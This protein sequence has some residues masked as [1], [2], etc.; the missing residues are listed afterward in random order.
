MA[1]TLELECPGCAGL[2]EL[3]AGFAGGVCRCSLCGTLMTVPADPA[4]HHAER[5]SRPDSPGGRPEAPGQAPA[6]DTVPKAAGE[7]ESESAADAET[8]VTDAGRVVRVGAQTVIPTAPKKRAV[9]RATTAA[10]FFAVVALLLAMMGGAIYVMSREAPPANTE[11]LA[12]QHFQYNRDVNPTTLEAPNVVGMSLGPKPAVIVDAS[13][14]SKPWLAQVNRLIAAGLTRGDSGAQ[15]ALMYAVPGDVAV[16]DGGMQPIGSLSAQRITRF[17]EGIT[18]SGR[19]ALRQ[20]IEA[21]VE[22]RPQ[23]IILVIGRRLDD[24]EARRVRSTLEGATLPLDV[25]AVGRDDAALDQLTR[26]TGGRYQFVGR[27][28]LDNWQADPADHQ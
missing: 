14:Q 9:V 2:L 21:A 8:F 12:L 5:L 7:P 22:M 3:D 1:Q 10:L 28:T 4:S 19:P 27:A 13:E 24:A 6:P 16:F 20:A 23:A 11:D 25:I 17:Q 18:A 26:D 15:V